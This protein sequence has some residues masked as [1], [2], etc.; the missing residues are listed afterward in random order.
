[1][2]GEQS[3]QDGIQGFFA[4]VGISLGL[5]PLVRVVLERVKSRG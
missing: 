1:M 4:L 3:T 5:V 2:A